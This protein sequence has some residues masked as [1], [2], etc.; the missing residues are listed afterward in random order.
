[1][2]ARVPLDL[3]QAHVPVQSRFQ[4]GKFLQGNKILKC[5]VCFEGLINAPTKVYSGKLYFLVY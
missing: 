3:A 2:Q 5:C 4:S 1:M